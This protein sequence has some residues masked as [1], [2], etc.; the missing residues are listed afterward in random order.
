M[1]RTPIYNKPRFIRN[2]VFCMSL[3]WKDLTKEVEDILRVGLQSP[4]Q[5][6]YMYLPEQNN[7]VA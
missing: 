2:I 3:Q 7:S 4:S 1:R 5:G 6:P